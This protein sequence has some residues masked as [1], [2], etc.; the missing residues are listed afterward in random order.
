MKILDFKKI[1]AFTKGSSSGNPAG[2]VLLERMDSLSEGEMQKL[3]S[4]LKGFVSEVGFACREDGGFHLKYYSSE[5]EVAFC[6]HATIAIMY[7]LISTD[8]GLISEKELKIRVRAGTL[9]VFNRLRE[10][11]AVYIT[12]PEPR[13]LKRDISRN[14]IAE[15]LGTDMKAIKADRAVRVIDGGLRTLI[16]PLASLRD[17]LELFPD[18]EVLRRFSLEKDFDIVHV[19]TDEVST[20]GTKYRTRVFAPKYGYLEDPATGS[21]NSA[22][23][24]YLIDEGM[25]E[26][27]FSIEQ[28]PLRDSPNIVGIKRIRG[29]GTDRIL[30]GGSATTRIKGKYL[31]HGTL[32]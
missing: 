9:P 30:F 1:D 4:E 28:G 32:A 14:E 18:R 12:A 2:Y 10:E 24:F 15:A 6:G 7:D 22:F 13:F 21:G 3:A 20:K 29:D 16:V 27:D 11:D 31:L 19:Y 25:W 8:P 17:C 5:C 23:G 26:D